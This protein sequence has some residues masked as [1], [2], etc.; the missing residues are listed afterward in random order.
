MRDEDGFRRPQAGDEVVIAAQKG[1]GQA[2]SAWTTVLGRSRP[3][4]H[5]VAGCG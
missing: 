1:E 3:P 2:L 4:L 5:P